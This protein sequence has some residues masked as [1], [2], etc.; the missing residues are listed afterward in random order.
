MFAFRNFGQGLRSGEI[1]RTARTSSDSSP[2]SFLRGIRPDSKHL[3]EKW[4]TFPTTSVSRKTSAVDQRSQTAS[5]LPREVPLSLL[6][7]DYLMRRWPIYAALG[8]VCFRRRAT[9]ASADAFRR[10]F[11][12]TRY[13]RFACHTVSSA[14]SRESFSATAVRL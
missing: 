6:I 12:S 14:A 9:K 10:A 8:M 5:L 4:V 1:R 3:P 11:N 13:S 2:L 7:G